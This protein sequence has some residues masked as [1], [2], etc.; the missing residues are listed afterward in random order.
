MTTAVDE[1]KHGLTEDEKRASDELYNS[2]FT[3]KK[4]IISNEIT[5]SMSRDQITKSV[6]IL[7]AI[8]AGLSLGTFVLFPDSIFTAR[9]SSIRT[10]TYQ[11]VDAD[12]LLQ[13]EFE[14]D[15]T[16]VYSSES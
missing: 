14:R 1:E 6:T 5:G 10:S 3:Q 13:R 16:S 8:V 15:P 4:K 7:S 9:D 12:S 2:L 11:F